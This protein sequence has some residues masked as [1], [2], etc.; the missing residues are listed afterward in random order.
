MGVG[1]FH[2]EGVDCAPPPTPLSETEARE[3][4]EAMFSMFSILVTFGSQEDGPGEVVNAGPGTGL[5]RF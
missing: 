4:K 3:Q 1:L 5:R 2:T